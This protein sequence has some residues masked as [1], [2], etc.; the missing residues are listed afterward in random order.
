TTACAAGCGKDPK[1]MI[2]PAGN[3][4]LCSLYTE[5]RLDADGVGS[6][7]TFI[8]GAREAGIDA[9]PGVDPHERGTDYGSFIGTGACV[10]DYDGDGRLDVLFVLSAGDPPCGGTNTGKRLYRNL[11]NRR[12]QDVTK[13]AGLGDGLTGMGC[14]AGDMDGDGDVDLFV[15]DRASSRLYE[16]RGGKYV[17][18][19]ANSDSF[20][21]DSARQPCAVFGDIDGDGDL[22]LF[23]AVW[24]QD[25][26]TLITYARAR[27]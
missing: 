25:P 8:E 21:P 12:F 17:D 11:G 9:W 27:R 10:F 6:R 13:E 23:V 20:N 4:P 26:E 18:I 16:N 2:E 1:M 22:D 7:I 5:G 3:H 14:S 19:T 24:G 15:T